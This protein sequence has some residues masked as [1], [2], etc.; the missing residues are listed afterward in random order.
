[1]Q[2]VEGSAAALSGVAFVCAGAVWFFKGQLKRL[3]ADT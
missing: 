2:A 1:M 3:Q